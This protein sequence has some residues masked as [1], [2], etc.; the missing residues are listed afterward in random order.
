MPAW[1]VFGNGG[2]GG[3]SAVVSGTGAGV[4]TGAGAGVRDRSGGVA[5]RFLETCST[6]AAALAG[7]FRFLSIRAKSGNSGGATELAW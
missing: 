5:V 2:N 3:S 4:V 7:S 6:L 1:I